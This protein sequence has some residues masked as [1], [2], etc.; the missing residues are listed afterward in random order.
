MTS[1]GETPQE[2]AAG[3]RPSR[4]TGT[5]PWHAAARK[6]LLNR[7]HVPAGKAMALAA[8]PTAVLMGMGLTSQLADAKPLPKNPFKDGPCVSAPDR[9]PG[10]ETDGKPGGETDG[11]PGGETEDA[12]G[13]QDGTSGPA[14]QRTP[15]APEPGAPPDDDSAVRPGTTSGAGPGTGTEEERPGTGADPAAPEP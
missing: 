11:K 3:T 7:L 1:D 6:S 14:G 12:G 8:M 4:R 10:G 2:G 15:A 13:A 9:E 5:G